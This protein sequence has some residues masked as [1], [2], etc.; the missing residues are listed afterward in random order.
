MNN[1]IV[2][3][4]KPFESHMITMHL[5][6]YYKI[7]KLIKMRFDT[8][9]CKNTNSHQNPFNKK[10]FKILSSKKNVIEIS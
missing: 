9:N 8:N 5:L 1:T 3:R 10:S 2:D 7:A 6:Y 4:R